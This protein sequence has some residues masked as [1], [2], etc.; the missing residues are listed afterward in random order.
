VWGAPF[1][2]DG[3]T[4]VTGSADGTVRLWYADLNDTID[5]LCRRLPRD[6]TEEEREQYGITGGEPTCPNAA[7]AP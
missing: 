1:S 6:L 4:I 7:P 2:P 3:K 5:D